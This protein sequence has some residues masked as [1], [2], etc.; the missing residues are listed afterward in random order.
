MKC[1]SQ[2]FAGITSSDNALCELPVS[3]RPA[4]GDGILIDVTGTERL[5]PFATAAIKLLS[6]CLTEG[7]LYVEDLLDMSCVFAVCNFLCYGDD[8]LHMVGR[9]HCKLLL[10]FLN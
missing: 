7:T 5:L 2:S 8:N 10:S 3:N 9:V 6:K 1:F 4:D